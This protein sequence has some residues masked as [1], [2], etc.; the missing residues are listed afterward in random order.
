[1]DDK[2]NDLTKHECFCT[3]S[4]NSEKRQPEMHKYIPM[5]EIL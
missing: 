1:M 5:P 4:L 3:Q 2:S